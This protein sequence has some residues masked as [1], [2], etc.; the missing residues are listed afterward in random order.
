M[1][2]VIVTR[3][4]V[5]RLDAASAGRHA[6]PA[7]LDGRLA[8]FRAYYVPSVARLG[9]PVVLLCST[10][11][12]PYV[13]E[14]L[15]GLAWASIVVQDS[16]YGGWSG[17]PDQV[18]TRLDSDDALHEG[19]FRRLD[20]AIAESGAASA[21]AAAAAI[22]A[23]CTKEFLRLDA[24]AGR[25]YAMARRWPSPLAAF[26][27]GANPYAQDHEAIEAHYP[28]RCLAGAWLLQ[29]AHGD[30]L[31]NRAPGWWRF[32]RRVP[33]RRLAPFGVDAAGLGA[34]MPR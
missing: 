5:P 25:L 10:G 9:V 14:R 26:T 19:W 33:R 34:G 13:A 20:A 7:W 23:F 18:V 27:G 31:S 21:H 11:S 15:G 4:S 17:A 22:G 24:H 8:L 3:F 16:W 30:N 6:E 2:H 29:I 12:A 28:T 32:Y 1:R